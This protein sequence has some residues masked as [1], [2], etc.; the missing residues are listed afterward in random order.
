MKSEHTIQLLLS[1]ML[2]WIGS[3]FQTFGM[4]ILSL[5][6]LMIIDYITGMLASR[7]EG[8][9]HPDNISYGWNSRKGFLGILEKDRVLAGY[10]KRF[11]CRWII[12]QFRFQPWDC[13]SLP[14]LSGCFYYS[15]VLSE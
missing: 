13:L 8:I 10:R 3:K 2:T 6:F 12:T 5:L 11:L 1:G 15:M 9:E 14:F 4:L 7:K